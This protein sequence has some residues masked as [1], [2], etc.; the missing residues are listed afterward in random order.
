MRFLVVPKWTKSH[1]DVLKDVLLLLYVGMHQLASR[2]NAIMEP[3]RL[4]GYLVQKNTNV[5]MHAN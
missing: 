3:A 1:L 4:V 2:I 5:A